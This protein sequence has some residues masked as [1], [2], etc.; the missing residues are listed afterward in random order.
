MRYVSH[1]EAVNVGDDVFSSGEGLVF[2]KG[3]ALGKVTAA[4]KGDLFYTITI[5]PALDFQ[6]LRYCTLVAKEDI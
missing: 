6:A 3:F 1:L 4:D 2:P 5:Q